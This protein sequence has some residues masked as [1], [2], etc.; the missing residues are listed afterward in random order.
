MNKLKTAAVASL[1]ILAA[2]TPAQATLIGDTVDFNFDVV[3]FG[4]IFTGSAVVT[5]PGVEFVVPANRGSSYSLD[6]FGDSFDIII[7]LGRAAAVGASVI[8]TLSDLDWVGTPG[9][10][11][12]VSLTGTNGNA[13][14]VTD[15]FFTDDSIAVTFADFTPPP[16]VQTYS[17]DIATSHVAVPEPLTLALVGTGLLGLAALRRRQAA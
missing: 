3:G 2:G 12:G 15:I 10:I 9:V 1:L 8:F 16:V 6:I 14:N 4:T 11:T 7:D 5:D 17:F 13:A